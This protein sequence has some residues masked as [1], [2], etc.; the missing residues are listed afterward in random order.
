M[1]QPSIINALVLYLRFFAF[2]CRQ[3]LVIADSLVSFRLSC[4][5]AYFV[6]V[7]MLMT[8]DVIK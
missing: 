7:M 1:Y 5:I 2:F 4:C 8:Y 6:P 3:A